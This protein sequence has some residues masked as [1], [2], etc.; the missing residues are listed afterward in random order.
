MGREA[1]VEKARVC[2][3]CKEL[4]YQTAKELVEHAKDCKGQE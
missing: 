1:R 3:K 4:V 2:P